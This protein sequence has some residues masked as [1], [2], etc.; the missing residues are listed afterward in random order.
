MIT[1]AMLT[2]AAAGGSGRGGGNG[3]TIP[4]TEMNQDYLKKLYLLEIK[5]SDC[6]DELAA[7]V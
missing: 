2:A 4:E 5:P 3:G 1:I 6:I 7:F